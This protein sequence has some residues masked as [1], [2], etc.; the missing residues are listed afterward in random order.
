MGLGSGMDGRG[1]SPPPPPG[2][3]PQT[4]QSVARPHPA[5]AVGVVIIFIKS[6]VYHRQHNYTSVMRL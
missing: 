2:F 6:L 3:D 5:S 4:A 1:K